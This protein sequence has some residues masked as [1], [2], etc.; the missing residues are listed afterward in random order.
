MQTVYDSTPVWLA[1]MSDAVKLSQILNQGVTC[2]SLARQV[3]RSD[4][5]NCRVA[6]LC[7]SVI[8]AQ[9]LCSAAYDKDT[10]IIE[11]KLSHVAVITSS[12]HFV[13]PVFFGN[14]TFDIQTPLTETNNGPLQLSLTK[15]SAPFSFPSSAAAPSPVSPQAESLGSPILC[16]HD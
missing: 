15:K 13:D 4:P 6:S 10:Q 7:F 3:V 16:T 2:I 14:S 11:T 8:W 5:D 12:D 1:A 9:L